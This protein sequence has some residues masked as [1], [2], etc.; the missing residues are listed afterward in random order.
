MGKDNDIIYIYSYEGLERLKDPIYLS[1]YIRRGIFKSY[2][3]NIKHFL[4][5][6]ANNSKLMPI[7]KVNSLLI[8][9]VSIV[10]NTNIPIILNGGDKVRL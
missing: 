6:I 5:S 3:Y 4:T 10:N 8:E 2:Y 1:L 9:K 7:F